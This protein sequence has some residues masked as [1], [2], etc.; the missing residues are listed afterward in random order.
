M[1][2]K[3]KELKRAQ[4]LS[5]LLA[6]PLDGVMPA[7]V[8][9]E[10]EPLVFKVNPGPASPAS[11]LVSSVELEESP[12]V[13]GKQAATR[14]AVS[15]GYVDASELCYEFRACRSDG[16]ESDVVREMMAQRSG[17]NIASHCFERRM[18]GMLINIIQCA[19]A[20]LG[21]E[22]AAYAADLIAEF[23]KAYADSDKTVLDIQTYVG[24][25]KLLLEI[26]AA[27]DYSAA[28]PRFDKTFLKSIR[29]D[30]NSAIISL[31]RGV[32][33]YPENNELISSAL[34]EVIGGRSRSKPQQA[35]LMHHLLKRDP[36]M[37]V[38]SYCLKQNDMAMLEAIIDY[39]KEKNI[40]SDHIKRIVDK[41]DAIFEASDKSIQD[42]QAFANTLGY[43][44]KKFSIADGSE[45][46]S[47]FNLQALKMPCRQAIK[48]AIERLAE[49]DDSEERA[50]IQRE[51][52]LAYRDGFKALG[53]PADMGYAARWQGAPMVGKVRVPNIGREDK[54]TAPIPRRPAAG[55][56]SNI[57]KTTLA[58]AQSRSHIP[59]FEDLPRREAFYSV[60]AQMA[61]HLQNIGVGGTEFDTPHSSRV[62]KADGYYQPKAY[63]FAMNM[64]GDYARSRL[65]TPECRD[66]LLRMEFELR[67]D[68]EADVMSHRVTYP[69]LQR[70][71]A[72]EMVSLGSGWD[73][74]GGGHA[75]QILFKEVAD[76]TYMIYANRGQRKRGVK[77]GMHV[78]EV[79]FPGALIDPAILQN[80]VAARSGR[81]WIEQQ[82]DPLRTGIAGSLGLRKVAYVE[83]TDQKTGNCTLAAANHSIQAWLMFD[84]LE[85]NHTSSTAIT[86]DEVQ[87][88]YRETK[89]EYTNIRTDSKALSSMNIMEM[90]QPDG[91]CRTSVA[92]AQKI[93]LKV[94]DHV[95]RKASCWRP[96]EDRMPASVAEKLLKPIVAYLV[97][98]ESTRRSDGVF[99]LRGLITIR[100]ILTDKPYKNMLL[101]CMRQKPRLSRA[102]IEFIKRELILIKRKPSED[103]PVGLRVEHAM[104]P[105]VEKVASAMAGVGVFS[106]SRS[107][108][109]GVGSQPL[110]DEA[111][112]TPRDVSLKEPVAFDASGTLTSSSRSDDDDFD[113]DHDFDDD[114]DP[115]RLGT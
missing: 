96:V 81:A 71:K 24:F 66:K 28:A 99:K 55:G 18:A 10:L 90:L 14:G 60:K 12:T 53:I 70:L 59:Q 27:E 34:N 49:T 76:R 30:Y 74:D 42:Y 109:P 13:R 61:F 88:S 58:L 32:D 84:W 67:A 38:V 62:V 83:K 46:D 73:E 105:I 17:M 6:D 35:H 82:D 75:I 54:V 26:N 107:Q 78:Y 89:G 5:K 36:D 4:E 7:G 69:M 29:A 16:A 33:E 94:I 101:E 91:T 11:S 56:V 2:R 1:S 103:M 25:Y 51:I 22:G 110:P 95:S 80:I 23:K 47:T 45:L 37:M 63:S 113:H 86:A 92:S 100:Q 102:S 8:P 111:I 93:T 115:A 104:Q 19:N 106:A 85:E 9:A 57:S 114:S 31:M 98:Q 87:E 3:A 52:Q 68:T 39:A 64:L 15:P 40:G 21:S 48:A 108:E 44:K 72:G 79:G 41:L 97:A 43:I 65:V 77:P 50:K 112:A 20:S